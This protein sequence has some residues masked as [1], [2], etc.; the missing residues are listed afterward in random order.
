[1]S[2]WE[3]NL[4]GWALPVNISDNVLNRKPFKALRKRP[5]CEKN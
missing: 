5:F 2:G 4:S 3:K 1:M